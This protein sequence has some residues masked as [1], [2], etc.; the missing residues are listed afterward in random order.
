MSKKQKSKIGK[1]LANFF[2]YLSLVIML[3][4]IIFVFTSTSESF[5]FGYKPFIIATGSMEPE[6]LTHSIVIIKKDD[7]EEIKVGDVVA[8]KPEQLNGAGAMHRVIKEV[9]EGYITKGDNNDFE[10]EGYLT[11]ENYTGRAIWH[12][13]AV[14]GV[15]NKLMIPKVRILL[16]TILAGV[17]LLAIALKI[18]FSGKSESNM[19]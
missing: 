2:L 16:G 8:F 9:P 12:T 15:I 18:I 3:L 10:D 5:L 1:I 11:I 19:E 13:N 4:T 17:V 14:V 6:Y 7:Y